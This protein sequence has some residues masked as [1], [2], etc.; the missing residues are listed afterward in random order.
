MESKLEEPFDEL[1]SADAPE[2]V[3]ETLAADKGVQEER[4]QQVENAVRVG[5][6]KNCARNLGRVFRL[7]VISLKVKD[8]LVGLLN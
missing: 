3:E 8:G 4:Y 5:L 7:R 2:V 1:S 6:N